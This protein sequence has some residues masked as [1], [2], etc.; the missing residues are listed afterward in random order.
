MSVQ[1]KIL[2]V[3]DDPVVSK[4]F[5]RVLANKG[6]AVISAANGEEALSKLKNEHYDLVFTDIKMPGISGLEVAEQVKASQ[7]W[8]PVVIVTGYGS[9]AYE[10]RAAAAG[11]SEFL[12]K[13]LSPEMIEASTA[14]ALGQR[15]MEAAAAERVAMAEPQIEP[16]RIE[17]SETAPAKG[18]TIK[19]IALFLAAPFIGL[20]YIVAMPFAGL[21][22]LAWAGYKAVMK[23]T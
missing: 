14:H 8:L 22:M 1:T 6:Y 19:N 2:I 5:D 11:V 7:P 3:D 17:Q 10:A 15:T 9:D 18:S 4:S 21:G 13:P 23:R 12:R 20:A 16:T